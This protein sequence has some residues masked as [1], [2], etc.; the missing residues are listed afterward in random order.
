MP[1]V[2]S[3][4]P[5]RTV[6]RA[7]AR[8]AATLTMGCC[9]VKHW[10]IAG[11]VVG[12]VVCLV[13]V[14]LI[15]VGN[16]VIESTVKK[17]AVLLPDTTAYKNWISA[18]APL[19][20]QFWLFDVQNP[21][22]VVKNGS[23][24]KLYQRG[25]YTYR[26]RYLPKE[27]VTFNDNY[28]VSFSL[29]AGAIFEPSMSVGPEEDTVTTL[30]LAVAGAYSLIDH[31][32]A[33][34]LI[35]LSKSTLFQNRTVKEILWGYKDPMLKSIMGLFYPYN[36][37]YDGPY[38]MFTG[39]DDVSKVS[40]IDNWQHQPTVPYWNDPYCNMIN[41]TDGSSFSPYLDKKKPLYFFPSD[42][43]RSVFAEYVSSEDLKG[44]TVYRYMLPEFTLASPAVNPDNKCF[45]SNFEM[46]N[47]CTM[48]GV[49]DI[50]P[51]KGA[52]VFMSL[53]H[54]LHG[55]P[56]LLDTVRGLNPN[57]EEHS[58]YLD[59]EPIT[60]FTLRF[61][62]RLQVNMVYGP[63]KDIRI[64]NQ[65]KNNTMFPLVWLNETAAL[66][67][68]TADMIKAE[69]FSR[70]SLL[71]TVQIALISSGAVLFVLCLIGVCVVTHKTGKKI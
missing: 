23:I 58:T 63:S 15:P 40:V 22:E 26:T 13:G 12:A 28:T 10:L 8:A 4:P 52:P 50:Q 18:G 48:A 30:N 1:H 11:S 65:V 66:D 57:S 38:N 9:E 31:K 69:L 43:C 21:E 29:P 19:Y 46:T 49:L 36:N 67:D 51:C 55:S 64:L 3:V 7:A 39:Q 25:P 41:G 6:A 59:V 35:Q 68:E 20:R 70:M 32:L 62:K 71:E 60:G 61:A 42:I 53:P 2:P 33:N 37:T 45:C 14:I 44:I 24:P 56:D 17:E 54:F 34:M 27:N 47:N 5:P 16:A